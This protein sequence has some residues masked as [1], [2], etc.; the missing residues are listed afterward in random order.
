MK[1]TCGSDTLGSP[2]H[3]DWCDKDKIGVS[4]HQIAEGLSSWL[5]RKQN[6]IEDFYTGQI[7]RIDPKLGWPIPGDYLVTFVDQVHDDV[8]VVEYANPVITLK[9]KPNELIIP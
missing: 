2:K 8:S 6:A 7:V 1:C 9:F 4:I 5:P 3:S